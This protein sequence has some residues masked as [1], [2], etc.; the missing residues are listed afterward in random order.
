MKLKKKEITIYYPS[1]TP[2]SLLPKSK[3]NREALAVLII[4]FSIFAFITV[5]LGISDSYSKFNDCHGN[6]KRYEYV[7][8]L[9][10][11]GCWLGEEPK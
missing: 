6:V 2:K 10:R 7:F 5:L 1:F 4:L 8:P 11:V 9:Y 3:T